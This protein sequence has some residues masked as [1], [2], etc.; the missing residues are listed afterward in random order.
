MPPRSMP[1]GVVKFNV[2]KN[3][4]RFTH[5]VN[6]VTR[7]FSFSIKKWGGHSGAKQK[8]VDKQNELYPI[9]LDTE[10]WKE[11]PGYPLYSVSRTGKIKVTITS[12]PMIC[13]KMH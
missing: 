1:R 11:I 5:T 4:Y 12:Y 2:S 13:K 10:V 6:G 9:I 3:A 7:E 8:C